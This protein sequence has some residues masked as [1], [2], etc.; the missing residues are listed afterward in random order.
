M[1]LR[2]ALLRS[3]HFSFEETE[4]QRCLASKMQGSVVGLIPTVMADGN[5]YSHW[6]IQRP[7]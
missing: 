5:I 4:A 3:F 6:F 7:Q 1:G 2:A